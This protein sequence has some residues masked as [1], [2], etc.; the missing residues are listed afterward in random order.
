[1]FLVM[2]SN[3]PI[4][5]RAEQALIELL[6]TGK[7]KPG[8]RLVESR[9]AKE[10]G[11]NRAAVREALNRLT[12]GDVV[13]YI[14]YS[15]Y[16]LKMFTPVDLLELLSLREAIEPV[17]AREAAELG[18]SKLIGAIEESMMLLEDQVHHHPENVDWKYDTDFHMAIV[19]ASGNTRFVRVYHQMRIEPAMMSWVFNPSSKSSFLS[20]APGP[21]GV[22]MATLAHHRAIFKAIKEGR[23][24]EARDTAAEHIFWAK[25]TFVR[26]S[27]PRLSRQMSRDK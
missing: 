1:M 27:L 22:E 5:E 8:D 2:T 16:R 25:D 18:D 3:L 15:G 24:F 19:K 12:A 7:I 26:F 14:P 13:E 17:A 23:A 9:L 20:A 10:M 21:N 11:F 4:V 6:A